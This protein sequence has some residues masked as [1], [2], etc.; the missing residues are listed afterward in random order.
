[1]ENLKYETKQQTKHVHL[2]AVLKPTITLLLQGTHTLSSFAWN[3]FTSN[4]HSL[5]LHF[6]SLLNFFLRMKLFLITLFKL[7]FGKFNGDLQSPCIHFIWDIEGEDSLYSLTWNKLANWKTKM[8][9]FCN[10]KF[11]GFIFLPLHSS[12]CCKL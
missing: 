6:K 5:M 11:A 10:R 1:M 8:I 2:F 4:L 9:F 7:N 12:L 3:T